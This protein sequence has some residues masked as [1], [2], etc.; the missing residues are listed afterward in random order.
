MTQPCSTEGDLDPR[1]SAPYP[2]QSLPL[3][4]PQLKALLWVQ[5]RN[6]Q[7]ILTNGCAE[8]WGGCVIYYFV[9]M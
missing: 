8:G 5:E 4:T 2:F 1:E 7:P 9:L 3:P 6:P